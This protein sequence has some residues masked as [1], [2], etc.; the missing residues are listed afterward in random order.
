MIKF[1]LSCNPD[2]RIESEIELISG[3]GFDFA[4][5]TMEEPFGSAKELR[6]SRN[7]IKNALKSE[8]IFATAH[9]PLETDLGNGSEAERRFW[10]EQANKMLKTAAAIGIMK[11][12]FHANWA[13]ALEGASRKQIISNHE[14]SFRALRSGVQLLLENTHEPLKD[15]LG[16]VASVKELHSTIDVGHAFMHGGNR[17]I[18]AYIR[19]VPKISHL[20]AHDNNGA[21]DEHLPI[22]CGKINFSSLV[23]ELKR[24]GFDGTIALE[25]FSK[26]RAL[27]K[28]SLGKMKKMW[29][30]S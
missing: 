15:M 14:K 6:K 24:T 16:I 26:N 10:I 8:G 21:D 12:N 28:M 3:M 30:S 19:N 11:I 5:I 7:A 2:K 25:V 4:E 18:T 1:G 17:M 13:S 23:K 9:A 20:H 27:A 29:L 22:G